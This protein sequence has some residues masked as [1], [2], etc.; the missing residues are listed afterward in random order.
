MKTLRF[1]V[2]LL[3]LGINNLFADGTQPPGSGT[4]DVPYEVSTLD[5]LL[6]IS[7]NSASWDSNFEQTANIDASETH[8]WNVN[9][10]LTYDGFLPIGNLTHKF[11]GSYNGQN[12]RITDLYINRSDNNNCGLFGAVNDA[13]I[14]YL[15][16]RNVNICG[17]D[18]VGAIVGNV[19]G[20]SIIRGCHSTGT[21]NG[22]SNVGGLAGYLEYY[23]TIV[24]S[25]SNADVT[26]NQ[27]QVGGLL[28]NCRGIIKRSFAK[29]NVHGV[30]AVGGLAGYS[31]QREINNCYAAGDVSGN[32]HTGGLV[33]FNNGVTVTHCYST[34]SVSANFDFG[35][36][37]GENTGSVSDSF[38][39]AQTSGCND[40]GKGTPRSTVEMKTLSTFLN[41]DW[42]F[43]WETH[44]G[45][46]DLW[47][48]DF[49]GATNN[50]YPYLSWQDD[51]A[52]SLPLFPATPAGDGTEGNPYQITSIE[53]LAWIGLNRDKWNKFYIQT[54]NI[55]ASSANTFNGQA[56][57]PVIGNPNNSFSGTYNGQNY[58]ISNA[59][60]NYSFQNNVG[61][62]GN[63]NGAEIQN[64]GIKNATVSGDNQVGALVGNCDG[65]SSISKC[66]STGSVTGAN[67]VGGLV[68]N[69][70]YYST[71]NKCYANADVSSNNNQ[72]GGL[73]GNSKGIVSNSYANGS[74]EGHFAIGGL[75]GYSTNTV[76]Y[77]YARVTVNGN[78]HTGGLVGLNA[79]TVAHCYAAGTVSA[80]F[81]F[82]GLIGDGSNTAENSFYDSELCGLIDSDRGLPKSTAEMKTL[83][84]FTDAGWDFERETDNGTA[85]R[86]DLDYSEA[87]NSGY[88]YLSWQ[89][90]AA[91]SLDMLP[92]APTSGDGSS[93]APYQIATFENLYWV[94]QNSTEWGKYFIQI[95]DIDASESS[96]LDDGAGFPPIGALANDFSGFYDGQGYAIDNLQI[97]RA[98]EN[99]IGLFGF[100]N[101]AEI[102]NIAL[103]GA[104]ITGGQY[105][106]GIAG[107]NSS[108]TIVQ[109]YTTGSVSGTSDVGGVTGSN[110]NCMV[111]NCYSAAEI[112]GTSDIGGL[113]GANTNSATIDKCYARGSVTGTSDVGGLVGANSA[114]VTSSFF[115]GETTG[116]S[117][118]SGKGVPK[119]TQAMQ[120]FSTFFNAGW[121]LEVE[122][123]NGSNNI[124]DMDYTGSIGGCYPYLSWQDGSDVS[125]PA[126]PAA[127]TGSSS[128]PYQIAS[129]S[130]LAW[131]NMFANK[132]DQHYIQTENIDAS[133]TGTWFNGA[134]FSPV[135]NSTTEFSGS[136]N[137]QLYTISGLTIDRSSTSDVGLFG[138]TNSATLENIALLN[139]DITGNYD[140]GC[141]V[142]NNRA[143]STVRKCYSTGN[144]SGNNNVGGIAGMSYNA[145]LEQCYSMAGVNGASVVGGLVGYN[146]ISATVQN[147]YALGNV[148]GTSDVGGLIGR[149]AGGTVNRC[150]AAGNVSGSSETGGLVGDNVSTVSESFYDQWISGQ[151][152][153][154]KGEPTTTTFM[155]IH[156]TFTDANWD[157]ATETA[158]G[159][160]DVWD[161]DY[162]QAINIGY[163]YL[164][165]QDG[166]DESLNWIAT[167]PAN[168]DGS[169][170]DPYQIANLENLGWLSLSINY[171]NKYYKQTADIDASA[172]ST[173][174][175]GTGFL[176]IGNGSDDFTGSYD[177]QSFTINS[178][179]INRAAPSYIGL[180]GY[181]N[182]AV[183][184]NLGLI[185]VNI[186]GV[187]NVGGLIGHI[188]TSS[189]VKKCYTTGSV[190]GNVNVGGLAGSNYNA[191]FGQCYAN[192][193]VSGST[194]VGGLVGSNQFSSEV[195]NCYANGSVFGTSDVGG[196]A[197]SNISGAT[198]NKSYAK[199]SVSGSSATGG[200]VGSNS[201][202]VTDCFYDSETTD[203]NDTG[204]GTPKITAEMKTLATFTDSDWDFEA[205]TANGNNDYWDMDCSCSINN[206][207]PFLSWLNG[208]DVSLPVELSSLTARSKGQTVALEWV[209]E[210]ERDNLGFVLERSQ[211]KLSWVTIASYLTHNTLEGQGTTSSRTEYTFTDKT[212]TNEADYTY[213]LFEV[214]IEG[215][216]KVIA[217]TSVHIEA[218]PETMQL[219]AAYPN[220]FNPLTTVTYQLAKETHVQISVYNT[221]GSHIKTL[222]N[223][224]QPPGC[225]RVNWNAT[226]ENGSK[227]PSG[228]FFI[229]MQT[230]KVTQTEKVLLIK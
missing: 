81:D 14:Q 153:T 71:I 116:Q 5:H 88:P 187:N 222:C 196:L 8:A 155:K 182:G 82:G 6:W 156:L 26:G 103:T 118:N 90:G 177:G 224:T 107:V 70:N 10:N 62:F 172:T 98:S 24:S 29:G 48:M 74:V 221:L 225:Y 190:T 141:L 57:L 130:E 95:A 167:Q 4:S 164:S 132:W 210:S 176:T 13:T 138:Y 152:D 191:L 68:G 218:L 204:K 223:G 179:T 93:G 97:S 86:W 127:G 113:T 198:L 170:G 102:K 174:N 50:G 55:D 64:M 133:T 216:Q 61:L 54:T 160:D 23:A 151:N 85:D 2:V 150:Y 135:G 45:T 125:I 37:V 201:A 171:W 168:G 124:W 147:S 35:G 65:Y 159:S 139:V 123:N 11:S 162:N 44:N 129:L 183:I 193:S 76:R 36:L 142:G 115:D 77:C 105:V 59:S 131:L 40:T 7:T 209:T 192:T 134:G 27:N 19:H 169:S 89:D 197:G 91:I 109:C 34:G 181:I 111:R 94:S 122:I 63:T 213:R 194:D 15:D 157:F 146:Y 185:N 208:E 163:P 217:S 108:A 175:G 136:Y 230:E 101:G 47:D 69:M 189:T 39:D 84:T 202:S 80:S 16:M 22:H 66:Y 51:A 215:Q 121:D 148:S 154:G 184:K 188:H 106:G 38:Y 119:T 165:W 28:G 87:I 104:D 25:Y 3:I 158:N 161:M 126:K 143:G 214:N 186:T 33:G 83:A 120:T 220:P 166:S 144:V 200:L 79:G 72:V 207:Y 41:F 49:S 43:E 75:V 60:L 99:F 73:L 46:G 58:R 21:V 30:Y 137:G 226:D 205:E 92:V 67:N 199:G 42:D 114:T 100:L 1:I 203:Q 206:G 173:W 180:F 227:V 229:R 53:D 140:V 211:D 32:N 12:Y 18:Q 145:A 149:N 195:N 56:G 128:N 117:D 78:N 31:Q 212:V 52:T 17:Y 178:L 228:T 110:N 96:A 20:Y 9:D 219:F 112:S